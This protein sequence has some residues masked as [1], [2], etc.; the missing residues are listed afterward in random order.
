[1]FPLEGSLADPSPGVVG[2]CSFSMFPIEVFDDEP[3]LV[4]PLFELLLLALLLLVDLEEDFL[5]DFFADFFAAD[6]L[7]AP[8]FAAF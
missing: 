4:P 2:P 3:P 1:M 5:A 6:F 8:F 7:V